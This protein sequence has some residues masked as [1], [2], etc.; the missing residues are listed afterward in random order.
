MGDSRKLSVGLWVLQ[1]LLGLFIGLASGVPK[2]LLPLDTLPMPIPL[3]DALVKFIGFCEVLGAVGLILPGLVRIQTWLTPLAAACIALLTVC[4]A[5]Y[6]VMARQPESAVFALVI[7]ALAAFV[8]WGRWRTVP[9]R[10]AGT[11]APLGATR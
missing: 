6:Q 11:G 1:V 8:A 5:V 7:G 3:P 9:L 2:L 4:A 10:D